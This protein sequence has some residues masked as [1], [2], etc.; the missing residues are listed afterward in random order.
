MTLAEFLSQCD[1]T[2]RELA[3]HLGIAESTLYKYISRDRTPQL[4]HAIKIHEAT[5]G[6]VSYRDM[7]SDVETRL[8]QT[9]LDIDLV[10]DYEATHDNIDTD[11]L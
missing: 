5:G 6:K 9:L 8:A 7:L 2:K 11:L 4:V 3:V 1:V 10:E